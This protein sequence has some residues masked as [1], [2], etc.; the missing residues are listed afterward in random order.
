MTL[1]EII[2]LAIGSSTIVFP[3]FVY[4]RNK[5]SSANKALLLLSI[6]AGPIWSTA[7]FLYGRALSPRTDL[8]SLKSIYLVSILTAFLTYWLTKSYPFKKKTNLVELVFVFGIGCYFIY[9]LFFTENFI[10]TI[11]YS[12]SARVPQLGISYI[13]WFI[14]FAILFLWRIIEIRK[15]IK[16]LTGIEKKQMTYVITGFTI[17]GL[18][19]VPTN[20]IFPFF[21]NFDYIWL[22][23]IFISI[24]INLITYGISTT[25]F[26]NLQSIFQK[27]LLLTKA[28]IAPAILGSFVIYLSNQVF[29]QI[30]F[31]LTIPILLLILLATFLILK[32]HYDNKQD[33]SIEFLSKTSAILSLEE[34]GNNLQKTLEEK[35]QIS[36]LNYGILKNSQELVYN[37]SAN[38]DIDFDLLQQ[39]WAYYKDYNKL[40]ILSELEY[41]RIL[42]IEE[43]N[44]WKYKRFLGIIEY[45]RKNNWEIVLPIQLRENN[46][47]LIFVGQHKKNKLYSHIDV[48]ELIDIKSAI[49][50]VLE[51]GL[52]YRTIKD[53]NTYLKQ[54][55]SEQTQ[56]LQR[57]VKQLQEARRKEADMIDIMGHEL[58]TPMS[59]VK[60]NTDLL[61]NFTENIEKRKEDYKKYVK[62]IQ[63]A[64]DTEIK[65]INTLL[66]S[67]KLEGDK[68]ELNPEKVDLNDQIKMALHAQE[69][70]AN[71]KGID[72]VTKFNT[73]TPYVFADHARTVEVLNSLID[74][75]VKY[76]QEGSVTV[77]TKDEGEYIRVFVIDT[78]YGMT[79]E[80][81]ENL[82]KKFYR[83]SN[84]TQ[85]EYSDDVDIVRPG[86]TGL[87]L[88]V[89]FGLVRK[90]GGEIHVES[91]IGKGSNFT[92]TLPK[93]TNQKSNTTKN[94]ND[95]FTRLGLR[96]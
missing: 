13:L 74:N 87:G 24:M 77:A 45:M 37:Y 92:F 66:S 5:K 57:K 39:F 41:L 54:K 94:S 96:E 70:R 73:D 29:S 58:R 31:S 76:T 49:K 51:R 4:F 10:K 12:Q 9:S 55:V 19:V 63:D 71:E 81:I 20:M 6:I 1:I 26:L 65:L 44:I 25:R 91:E 46:L 30:S 82:G 27:L 90:M 16:S 75:A 53:F 15:D 59:V 21:G 17:V 8:F 68:I 32:K 48:K 18:G 62:R 89:T 35:L 3:L 7:I 83:T 86:G 95:M 60:L 84:Y 33:I 79:K 56:E 2:T 14:W 78:G 72:L 61:Q 69:S 52:L 47:A 22:G 93:Y 85:S 67:A 36:D 34:I 50:V 11:L 23:P 88:Y 40:L 64:V 42:S 28:L 38:K 80:D 43:N